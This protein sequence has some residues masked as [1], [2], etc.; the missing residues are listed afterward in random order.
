MEL[1]N[2]LIPG[3]NEFFIQFNKWIEYIVH[4]AMPENREYK[5]HQ[6][7][8]S[9]KLQETSDFSIFLSILR[10]CLYNSPGVCPIQH[11]LGQAS[12][13]LLFQVVEHSD[14]EQHP[15]QRKPTSHHKA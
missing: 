4:T 13:H 3:V 2:L 14:T 10:E 7:S 1:Y 15:A 11:V 5:Q 8:S 9:T 12:Y 6:E